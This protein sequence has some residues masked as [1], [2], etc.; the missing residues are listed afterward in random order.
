MK[1]IAVFLSY[2]LPVPA[3]RGGA[4][5]TL[6]QLLLEENEKMPAP[7]EFF[8]FCGADTS[9]KEAA[10]KY[11]YANF[12]FVPQGYSSLG[13]RIKKFLMHMFKSLIPRK[14]YVQLYAE[15]CRAIPY[16]LRKMNGFSPD[17]VLL[18]NQPA[19]SIPLRKIFPKSVIF[20]HL[21]NRSFFG[22]CVRE[23]D[24][25][26]TT[27]KFLCVSDYIAQE[28]RT[29]RFV[30]AGDVITWFNGI[31]TE[32]FSAPLPPEKRAALREKWGLADE[33]FV[34]LFSGRTVKE[35]GIGELLAAFSL[36]EKKVS[37]VKL[38]ILGASAFSGSD[39]NW[40]SPKSN[41]VIFSGYVKH[42]EMPSA[43]KVADVAVLPSQ[44][45]DPC[46]LALIE[47]LCAGLPT[48]ITDSGG[49]PEIASGDS[50][51]IVPRGSDFPARL[52][53]AMLF[54]YENPTERMR[55][56]SAAS[57]RGRLLSRERYYERFREICEVLGSERR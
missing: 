50:A 21:H 27:D 1:K 40:D 46:P 14:L 43:I 8:I 37:N 44:W 38:L 15:E 12:F 10:R 4:V 39:I 22:G 53:E 18:E 33:D 23:K 19:F 7:L 16:F 17:A 31:D 20:S 48:I 41:A 36:V 30:A 24:M 5:E 11:K 45:D 56:S 57:T 47:T 34:F 32:R 26:A 25:A 52:A 35:K 42:G 6:C 55:L 51:L 54:L 2:R 9:A 13:F 28:V 3:T 29:S 49:M